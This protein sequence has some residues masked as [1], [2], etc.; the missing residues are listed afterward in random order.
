ME[1]S[2]RFLYVDDAMKRFLVLLAALMC[3]IATGRAQTH[4]DSR[5]DIGARGGITLSTVMFKP[6]I[7]G[8]LGMG[9]TGGV[10]IR[11]TDEN[12]FGLIE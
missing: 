3:L 6:S 10:M 1:K 12:H 11:Y 4:F 8:K 5:V 2:R 7:M 9:Y